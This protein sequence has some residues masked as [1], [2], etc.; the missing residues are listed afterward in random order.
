MSRFTTLRLLVSHSNLSPLL[1]FPH[2]FS[3]IGDTTSYGGIISVKGRIIS[4]S[5]IGIMQINIAGASILK[6][7]A[8][9]KTQFLMNVQGIPEYF[10]QFIK[11][12]VKLHVCR[13][14]QLLSPHIYFDN[15]C[16]FCRLKIHNCGIHR[17]TSE[18]QKCGVA[19][20]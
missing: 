13:I 20:H 19:I 7:S 2:M 4:T 10:E 17:V 11:C 18:T 16:V 15:D 9:Y 6:R 12:V 8:W 1:L 5:C 14:P 3:F